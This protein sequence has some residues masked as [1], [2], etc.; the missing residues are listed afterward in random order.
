[1]NLFGGSW[2]FID[3]IEHRAFAGRIGL[4]RCPGIV[5]GPSG[6]AADI[7]AIRAEGTRALVSLTEIEEMRLAG[8]ENLGSAARRRGMAWYHLP[9]RDFD[10][11]DATFE[12]RWQSA[13]PELCRR[14]VDG[15][16][17]A[18]HCWAGLGRSGMIAARLLVEFGELPPSAIH[19]VRRVRP[20]AIQTAEQEDYVLRLRPRP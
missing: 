16:S 19:L 4:T 12:E 14:L 10:V 15:E 9:I 17:V 20:G 3:W 7:A 8:V 1:M 13:G 5:T 11:P 6:L 2:G 18:I